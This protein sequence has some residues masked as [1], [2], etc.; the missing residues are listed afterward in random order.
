MTDEMLPPRRLELLFEAQARAT[1]DATALIHAGQSVTYAELDRQSNQF[2][3]HLRTLAVG[4]EVAVAVCVRRS[5]HMVVALFGILKAG[6]AY[7]PLDRKYPPE[8]LDYIM[9]DS[10]ASVLVT[11]GSDGEA[12]PFAGQTLDLDRDAAI[13]A[14]APARRP[15]PLGDADNLA[16]IIYTSGSTGTPKGVM[17]AHTATHL[18]DWT[19]H[20]LSSEDIAR[21]AATTSLSFDPSIFEIFVP[22]CL[23]GA[24]VIKAHALKPF[25]DD[26]NPTMLFGT[27]SVLSQLA[28]EGQI[29]ESVRVINVGGEVVRRAL[30]QELYRA[31]SVERIYNQYGPTEATTCTT[32]ALLSRFADEP[33]PIGRPIGLARVYVLDAEGRPVSEGAPGEIHIAGPILA[34]GY[35]NQS[36]LTAESFVDDP[37]HDAG[38]RMYRTGDLGRWSAAGE[39]EFLGRIDD[40][41][42]LAG[43]RVEPGEVEAAL[44]R[45]PHVRQAAVIVENN[46]SGNARLRAYVGTSKV[47]VPRELREQLSAWLPQHMLPAEFVFLDHL[48]LTVSG[49]IDRQAL[50]R[51]EPLR[52][53]EPSRINTALRTRAHRRLRDEWYSF[54]R[55]P[56]DVAV[57]RVVSDAWHRTLSQAP[58][59]PDLTWSE[60]GGDS[61]GMLLLLAR[62]ERTLGRKLMF[63]VVSADM[64]QRQLTQSLTNDRARPRSG[65]YPVVYL[66]PG[67]LGDELALADFRRA[68]NQI[69][70]EVIEPPEL[71]ATGDLL[72][73]LPETGRWVARDIARRQPEGLAIVAGFSLGG[74]V[75][76]A[77]V[78]HLLANGF[79]VGLLVILDTYLPNGPKDVPEWDMPVHDNERQVSVLRKPVDD[80]WRLCL[81]RLL[82][83]WGQDDRR[84]RLLLR[85]V[86]CLGS[87]ALS[88]TRRLLLWGF[89]RDAIRSWQPTT[90]AVPAIVAVSREFGSQIRSRWASITP[91]ATFIELP[92]A[93]KD[94]LRPEA[95]AIL[96]PALLEAFHRFGTGND[97]R[98]TSDCRPIA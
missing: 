84:R 52:P 27:P 91:N 85:L 57:A 75:A 23:G 2:A 1:P 13:I 95:L 6:A 92:C 28:S 26:E 65:A 16:Y 58:R 56:T 88:R 7:V 10:A 74:A 33:L 49:K 97:R 68:F 64:T 41:V 89:R 98:A 38:G 54:R 31:S 40:Q 82:L 86:A 53:D 62:L 80:A 61:L 72:R 25:S 78:A 3:Q 43:I 5:I 32:V 51:F 67:I 50:R 15:K 30:I 36:A 14:T 8:R 59:I 69:R 24:V 66:I 37:F 17:L 20:T 76:H 60:A 44:L 46:A 93:H 79:T 55:N 21:V 4:P 81:K 94:V 47:L 9:R 19:R 39:L 11:Q 35:R 70:F 77:A 45:L 42:K 73:S 12:L 63:D 71:D 83:A 29:P 90:L 87:V 34:R 22:L 48:P 18:V 96:R